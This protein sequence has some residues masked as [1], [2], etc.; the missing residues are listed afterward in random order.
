MKHELRHWVGRLTIPVILLATLSGCSNQSDAPKQY[1]LDLGYTLSTAPSASAPPPLLRV[2]PASV[3]ADTRGGRYDAGTTVQIEAVPS[4][5]QLFLWWTI[6]DA[7]GTIMTHPGDF[8][9]AQ[10]PISL[11]LTGPTMADATFSGTWSR[12][13][14]RDGGQVR[15]HV[16]RPGQKVRLMN[17]GQTVAEAVSGEHDYVDLG[18][19]GGGP[20]QGFFEIT[21][22][23][24]KTV[25]FRSP[26]Y[27]DLVDGDSFSL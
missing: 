7:S 2:T 8:T 4:Y 12:I 13:T 19:P 17:R 5:G 9:S 3:E 6:Y 22:P 10:N 21:A 26:V 20:A 15:V 14:R 11:T 23:D 27:D 18:I 25:V 1:R 16:I 24:G